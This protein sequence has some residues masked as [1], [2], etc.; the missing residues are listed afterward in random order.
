MMTMST[1]EWPRQQESIPLLINSLKKFKLNRWTILFQSKLLL[2]TFESKYN[3]F[4][5]RKCILNKMLSA[6]YQSFCPGLNILTHL[7]QNEMAAILQMTFLISFFSMKS[8]NFDYYF[9]EVTVFFRVQ[10]TIWQHCFRLWLGAEEVPTIFW[11]NDGQFY[12]CINASL[13]FNNLNCIWNPV[14]EIQKWIPL[15]RLACR[16]D[17]KTIADMTHI[18]N[19]KFYSLW[20]DT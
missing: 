20:H 14:T 16:I 4:H 8:C 3:N 6:I 12:W 10:L 2:V 7:D 1:K 9:T 18:Q 17:G 13:G 5:S 11:T 15:G 19:Q